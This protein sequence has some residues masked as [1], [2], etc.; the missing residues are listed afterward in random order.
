MDG[1][2]ELGEP[3]RV[4][5]LR[6]AQLLEADQQRIQRAGLLLRAPRI[7]RHG[8]P[9]NRRD[10]SVVLGAAVHDAYYGLP[11]HRPSMERI[12][13]LPEDVKARLIR[14]VNMIGERTGG[15]QR[16]ARPLQSSRGSSRAFPEHAL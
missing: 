5:D 16:D 7:S 3:D 1:S 8:W 12:L 15:R 13:R 9:N 10:N 4:T 6:P 2:R 11:R 14:P